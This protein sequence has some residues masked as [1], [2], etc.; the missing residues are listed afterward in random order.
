MI[1]TALPYAVM[2]RQTAEFGGH[3]SVTADHH[4]EIAIVRHADV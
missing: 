3:A 4:E 2:P 1:I